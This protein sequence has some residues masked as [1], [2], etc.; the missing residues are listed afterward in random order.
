VVLNVL[1]F[2]VNIEIYIYMRTFRI[3]KVW[4]TFGGGGGGEKLL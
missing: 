2:S 3:P 4:Y 1:L